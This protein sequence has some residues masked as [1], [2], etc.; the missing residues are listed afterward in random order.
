MLQRCINTIEAVV[1]CAGLAVSWLSLLMVITTF[2]VVVLRYLFDYGLIA[3]Q[4]SI[5]YMHALIFLVGAAYTLQC[6]AH[7][8]VDIIYQ[9]LSA[10]ARAGVN[11]FGNVFFL[12]PAMLFIFI[13]SWQYVGE[14]WAVL[15][16]SREAGGL[17]GVFLLKTAILLMA[18]LMLL[19]GI[20]SSLRAIQILKQAPQR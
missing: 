11:L 13:I 4:E 10:K 20:A 18:A 8:R 14:S 3:M 1:K 9:R 12:G 7:V 19:Q 2:L 15:E 5:I 16:T 17:P 6:D